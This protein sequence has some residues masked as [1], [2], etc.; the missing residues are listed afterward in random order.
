MQSASAQN[1]RES[2]AQSA[3]VLETLDS[4]RVAIA[5]FD[6]ETRL[7]YANAHLNYIFHGLPPVSCLI[8]KTYDEIVRLELPEIARASLAAGPDAF[9]AACLAQFGDRAWTPHDIVL[10]DGR[11]IEVKARRDRNNQ[12]IL[13]WNDVTDARHQFARLE[14][15]IRLSA[16]AFAFYDAH[17]RFV[18]GNV[19]YAQL[20]GLTLEALKGQSFEAI[21][22]QVASSG[23]LALDV[24][25]EDWVARRLRGHCSNTSADTL[26]TS[27][28]TAYLV[29]DCATADGG[30]AVVFTDI[31]EKTRAEDALVQTQQVL[32]STRE[33]AQRQ[34]G[35]LADLT[36]QLNFATAQ[37]DNAKTMLL[38]TMSHELKTPLNAILGFSDLM[39]ALSDNL[40]PAQIREYAGLIHQGGT[41]LLKMLN[42]IM[43]LTKISAGRYDL[44]RAPQDA[45]SMMWLARENFAARAEAK[46]IIIDADNCPAGMMIATDEVVFG[47]MLNAL[48]DNAINFT[49][50]GGLV[51]LSVT[52]KGDAV[53]LT[54]LDNGPGV[55]EADL[56]RILQPF[57]H[58]GRANEHVKGAGLGLTLVKAFAELHGGSLSL[59]SMPGEGFAAVLTI[60]AIS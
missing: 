50:R 39:N 57:E 7:L 12:V 19:L 26:Q 16:D 56:N 40:K 60:P 53:Q 49:Q 51:I 33:V 20:A 44:R 21:V 27:S 23:R 35:Y 5:I 36:K 3:P 32:E 38:R 55:A 14:E 9:V 24:S 25:L 29:R 11:V 2:S 15:A 58:A 10:A 41:N 28:G 34:S 18:T 59:E 46:A 54:V 1:L 47:S 17:D 13:L 37:A 52:R 45:G 43:D 22:R 48:V 6:S 30:R 8:G 31:T 42:Q 4:L